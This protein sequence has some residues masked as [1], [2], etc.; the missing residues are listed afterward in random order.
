PAFIARRDAATRFAIWRLLDREAGACREAYRERCS[1]YRHL[2]RARSALA[3]AR[4]EKGRA[5]FDDEIF[6][7]RA[8]RKVFEQ[9]LR[10]GGPLLRVL[11]DRC[12]RA[13]PARSV[14]KCGWCIE[15]IPASA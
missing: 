1:R 15:R 9:A 10:H 11:R 8:A 13:L 12:R 6:E 3:V 2:G 5:A 4:R 14:A 7:R